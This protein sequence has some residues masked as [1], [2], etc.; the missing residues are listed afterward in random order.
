MKK[1]EYQCGICKDIFEKGWTDQEAEDELK[2]TFPGF[3]KTEC[4]LVCDDCFKEHW[5]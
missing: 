5:K 3:D 4:D 1:N 2:K